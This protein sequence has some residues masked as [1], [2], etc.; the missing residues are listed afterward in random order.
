MRTSLLGK[1]Y[2]DGE[3]IVQQGEK[4]NHMFVIQ[5]GEAEVTHEINGKTIR[6]SI[7]TSGD[8][9]GEMALFSGEPRAATV[10]ARGEIRILTVDKRLFMKR[11]HE[12]PSMAFQ[13]LKRMSARIRQLNL[14]VAQLRIESSAKGDNT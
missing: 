12:D 4:G 10:R 5:K 13:I 7:L 6:L 1:I 3:V 11:V 8:I 9:F 2:Q 14:E